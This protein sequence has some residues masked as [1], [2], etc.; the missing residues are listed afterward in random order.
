MSARGQRRRSDSPDGATSEHGRID[1]RAPGF[2]GA[3]SQAS[4]TPTAISCPR[5]A[6]G[7]LYETSGYVLGIVCLVRARGLLHQSKPSIEAMDV[8][9]RA[10]LSMQ[11]R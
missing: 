3:G 9:P 7:V 2:T 10:A 6:S 5:R 4:I 1:R 8:T 11:P